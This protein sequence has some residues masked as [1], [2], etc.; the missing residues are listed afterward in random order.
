MEI[1]ICNGFFSARVNSLGAELRSFREKNLEY[2]WQADPEYWGE[3]A[4][5]LFPI[6]C[7]LR[8]G[9]VEI[10]GQTYAMERH[11]FARIM[12]FQVAEASGSSVTF[13][14]RTSQATLRRYPYRFQLAVRY[15][16]TAAGLTVGIRVI[17][18]D[19]RVMYYNIGGH[20]GFRCPL[21]PG[22][23]FEDYRVVLDCQ[24]HLNLPVLEPDTRLINPAKV[25]FRLDGDTLPLRYEQFQRDVLILD[26]L[27][28]RGVHLVNPEGNGLRMEFPDFGML[29]LWTMA[30]REAPYLC[31]E[32]WNG[33][34]T[35]ADED[36]HIEHKR[37]I[38]RLK[39][40][41]FRD[42]YIRL[43]PVSSF[44]GLGR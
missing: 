27:Q 33:G 31:M 40:G 43:I 14:L 24:E 2:I 28:S 17:N 15:T 32:P 11:G 18:Q 26:G 38:Q 3:S 36:D 1:E 5:W 34:C 16:L 20:P 41:G 42:Y 6:V 22:E 19:H 29:G 30:G 4:P 9:Q 39:P 44:S 23:R 35:Y 21:Y 12:E 25:N 13:V 37:L 10:E 7:D 8:N